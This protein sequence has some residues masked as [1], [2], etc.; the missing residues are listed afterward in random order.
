MK[1]DG[2]ILSKTLASRIQKYIKKIAH[3]DQVG[4]IPRMQALYL[5]I[6]INVIYHIN[7][8]QDKTIWPSQQRQKKLLKIFSTHL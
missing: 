7:K 1:I 3:Y 2:K 8:L 4:L 6:S 5:C